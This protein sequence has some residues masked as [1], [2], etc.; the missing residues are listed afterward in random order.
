LNNVLINGVNLAKDVLRNDL[1]QH[2]TQEILSS[3]HFHQAHIKKLFMKQGSKINNIDIAKWIEETVFIYENY[4]IYGKT[5]IEN[6][7]VFNNLIVLGEIN[8]KT[9]NPLTTMVKDKPQII[10][11]NF[12]ITNLL[13]QQQKFLTNNIANLYIQ[14]INDRPFK[15]ILN[16]CIVKNSTIKIPGRLRFKKLLKIHTIE[17]KL[18]HS[19]SSETLDGK[20]F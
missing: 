13:P 18:V 8:N 15:D 16:K 12:T 4:T 7:Q 5:Q 1:P 11:G 19:P 10:N 9:I 20:S 14:N 6:L 3:K 17:N 2:Q